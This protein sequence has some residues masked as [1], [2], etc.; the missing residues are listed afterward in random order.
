[1]NSKKFSLNENDY[2][3]MADRAKE[4]LFPLAVI[5]LPIVLLNIEQDG[6]QFSDFYIN[7]IQQG[8]LITYVL[9]RLFL[10]AQLF[11]QG[12]K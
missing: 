10:A 4:Y 3:I 9:N 6:F 12:K 2:R 5:Y 11:I 8:A 7:Q 1:M